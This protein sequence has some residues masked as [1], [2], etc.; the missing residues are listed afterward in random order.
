[1]HEKEEK[2]TH[3]DRQGPSGLALDIHVHACN[4]AQDVVKL[5]HDLRTQIEVLE[6]LVPQVRVPDYD[7]LHV[8]GAENLEAEPRCEDLSNKELM[9]DFRER[10]RRGVHLWDATQG[11]ALIGT[12]VPARRRLNVLEGTL[13]VA[14]PVPERCVELGRWRREN[15]RWEYN[16]RSFQDRGEGTHVR[17]GTRGIRE[18]PTTFS[19]KGNPPRVENEGRLVGEDR[20]DA[21]VQR[22]TR[23]AKR[24]LW[25]GNDSLEIAQTKTKMRSGARVGTSQR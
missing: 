9:G 4:R 14:Q 19:R 23:H 11:N 21:R 10:P 18:V 2:R 22:G 20:N 3:H 6:H 15:R 13:R 7:D 17:T 25:R 24:T 16:S 5:G 12:V 1:M 8:R